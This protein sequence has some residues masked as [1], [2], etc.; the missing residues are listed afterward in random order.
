LPQGLTSATF[1]QLQTLKTALLAIDVH[2]PQMRDMLSHWDREF[3]YGFVVA[4]D[5]DYDSLEQV[6]REKEKNEWPR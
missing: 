1:I 3:A 4:H 6:I 5:A 2:D